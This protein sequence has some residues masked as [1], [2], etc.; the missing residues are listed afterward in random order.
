MIDWDKIENDALACV[1]KASASHEKAALINTK[2]VLDAFAKHQVSDYYLKPSTGYA[3]SDTGRDELDGVF[4][5][6]FHTESA[7]VRSQFVSG[8]HTLAVALLGTLKPGDELIAA[9]GEPYDTMQTIIGYPVKTPG[10]LVD[11]GVSYK[12]IPMKGNHPD[13]KAIVDA[14]TPKTRMV[15][16]QRSCGYSSIRKTLTVDEIGEIFK[17]VKAAKPDVICFVDN[18]Y[19]EFI[20]DKEPTDVGADLMAGSL[21]KNPGGGIAPTGGYIVGR[22]D[23]VEQASYRLTAP[24]LGGEM[25][26]TLG[27]TAREFYQGLFLAPHVALQAVKTSIFAASVFQSLGFEVSPLP[28]DKRSDIIQ[29]ITLNTKENLCRFCEAIQAHSPIDSHVRPIPSHLPGYQDEIIMAAGTFVQ[30]A[31]IE[32][33]CDGPCREPYKVYLQG[34]LTFEHGH[35][36]IMAAAKQIMKSMKKD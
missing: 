25:G 23:L 1:A 24:G 4:A 8:T 14:I 15:H 2:K 28:E 26:A 31:S 16:V 3:Y 12:Q 6:I 18:C 22:A 7:L 30:G 29:T 9:T 20:E 34:G 27:D 33:S 17:A 10:S 36:A 21:I 13:I 19:G 32:L 5:D 11:L 35:I